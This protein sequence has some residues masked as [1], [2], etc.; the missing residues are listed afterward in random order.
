VI[1]LYSAKVEVEA[2]PKE[3]MRDVFEDVSG[4]NV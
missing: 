2:M 4:W 3:D 1:G